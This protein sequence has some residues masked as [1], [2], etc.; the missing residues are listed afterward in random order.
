MSKLIKFNTRSEFDDF[1]KTNSG[2]DNLEDALASENNGVYD[3]VVFIA[4][5]GEI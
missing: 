4:D 3:T 2:L 5:T 1:V